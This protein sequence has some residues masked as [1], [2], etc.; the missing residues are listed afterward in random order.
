MVLL[1]ISHELK[2]IF[3]I[4][5]NTKTQQNTYDPQSYSKKKKK[6]IKI[7]RVP[8]NGLCAQL[9]AGGDEVVKNHYLGGFK[10]KHLITSID[11][12]VLLKPT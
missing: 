9:Q 7:N 4:K 8:I 2:T 5:S 6:E 3:K 1:F 11:L 12:I 10:N